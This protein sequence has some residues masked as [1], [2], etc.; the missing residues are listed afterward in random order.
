MQL[1]SVTPVCA[2]CAQLPDAVFGP[3]AEAKQSVEHPVECRCRLE[4]YSAEVVASDLGK[5]RL[6]VGAAQ[7]LLLG[8][9]LSGQP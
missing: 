3:I 6:A 5:A 1:M 9:T 8:G 4:F 7:P 2:Y